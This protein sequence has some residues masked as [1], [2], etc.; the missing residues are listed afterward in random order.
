M[1]D[2]ANFPMAKPQLMLSQA[3][4]QRDGTK[5]SQTTY[6]QAEWCRFYQKKP[7]KMLGCR[8]QRRDIGGIVR[9]MD[10]QSYDGY[11][12]V[13]VGSQNV[14]Q[15]Y[16]INLRT[17]LTT[18]LT[19]RTP[20][21][22][23]MDPDN[24][25]QFSL[26]YDTANNAN[27]LLAHAA[28]NIGDIA[29]T[30]ERLVYFSEVRDPNPFLPIVGSEVS[31]GIVALWPYFLRYGNDGEV[32]WNVPGNITDL[33]GTGSGSARPWG[34]KIIKG[35]PLRGNGSGPAAL[36]WH[37]DALVR[38]QFVGGT[39]IFD[40]DTLTTST[41]LMSSSG[42]IEHAGIYYWMTVSGFQMFNGVVRDMGNNM[43]RQ[44]LLDN[45]NWN[46]RQKI[47]AMK[48][49]RWHELWWAV[50][51]FGATEPNWLFIYNYVDGTWFDTPILLSG[52]GFSSGVYEQI[53]HYPLIATPAIN[54][55]TG[56]TSMW[57]HDFGVD[58]ISGAIPTPK[59]IRSW[60]RTEEFNTA[61][62]KQPG[63]LGQS[64]TMSF[65]LVEPDFNQRGD[66]QIHLL[67]RANARANTRRKGPLIVPAEPDGNEQIAKTKFTGRMTSFVVL[68]NT[69][70]GYYEAGSPTFHWQPA[71]GRTEDGGEQM[72]D[73]LSDFPLIPGPEPV[74]DMVP[75]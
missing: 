47:F 45:V 8:E 44:F 57:Q 15:R 54:S 61:V 27:L 62:P 38:C 25:W 11:S 59:A 41:A 12:W 28:P 5:L 50:P 36:L 10:V 2:G 69:L 4:V 60:Y 68:S 33:V 16:N 75:S 32:A 58:E 34:T 13:H 37:L 70:G 19:D 30:R 43:N 42:I 64:Q 48:V 52:G 26:V 3:G 21:G 23:Q 14:L 40:F 49:P 65:S 7:R 55:E 51:M 22:F 6:I 24:N 31:G 35:M 66:L 53:Y 74:G 17:G 20:V 39:R 46:E 71:D 73:L 18:G 67:T 56:G 1:P 72:T 63:Q 29:D 9:G